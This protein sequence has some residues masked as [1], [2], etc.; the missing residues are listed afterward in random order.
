MK[1][2]W[3]DGV[4]WEGESVEALY[5]QVYRHQGIAL[6]IRFRFTMASRAK[7]WS[8]TNVSVFHSKSGFMRALADARMF[9]LE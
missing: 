1:L 4:V 7:K 8:N 9:R 6:D 5:D 2:I 3:P